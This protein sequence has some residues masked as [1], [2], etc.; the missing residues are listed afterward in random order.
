MVR[1]WPQCIIHVDGDAFFASCEQAANPQLRGKPVVVGSDRGIIA[2]AS[3]E[4]KA[5]GVTRGVKPW[6]AKK[7]FPQLIF[8][9]SNYELYS[10]M[11]A[12]MME[13]V[14]RY[15]PTVEEY[16]ID[17]A[18]A[19]LTG[20]RRLHHGSYPEIAARIQVDIY[21]ELKITVSVGVSTTKTLAKTAS[22]WHKPAGFTVISGK[23]IGHF[24]PGVPIEHVW[25]VGPNTARLLQKFGVTDAL[26]FACL[27]LER[28][29]QLLTKPGIELWHE[30]NGQTQWAV[31]ATARD[32]QQSIS[33]IRTFRP[34]SSD[35]AY[36]YAQLMRN[37]EQ[38][39]FKARRYNQAP[40]KIAVVLRRQEDFKSVGA[41]AKL[42]R[43]SAFPIEL[44]PVIQK[45]FDQVYV[46]DT[47]YRATQIV[48]IDLVNSDATQ[49]SLFDT[50][51]YHISKYGNSRV[52]TA[53]ERVQRTQKLYQSLDQ[54][55]RKYGQPVVHSSTSLPV[56]QQGRVTALSDTQSTT[57]HMFM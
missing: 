39:C 45:L 50:R 32:K 53:G 51:Y 37:V 56:Y 5:L 30:I 22:H 12:R 46:P 28:V 43:P 40:K 57:S 11:S 25:N 8:L 6:E 21:E 1:S 20:L 49:L 19:D 52:A 26:Q 18:F 44:A 17:E 36:V 3:Y 24:L 10:E 35:R 15:T 4:A 31:N 16:S 41:E 33:K 27:P 2:A 23:D 38:A 42:I 14:Y 48:L 47:L 55:R 54:L 9:P 34:A 13:I 29:E 7:K